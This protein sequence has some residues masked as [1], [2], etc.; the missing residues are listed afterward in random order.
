MVSPTFF[1]SLAL[2]IGL[3]VLIAMYQMKCMENLEKSVDFRDNISNLRTVTF[4]TPLQII[5][6]TVCMELNKQ[7]AF[8]NSWKQLQV[9][10][11]SNGN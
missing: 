6:I 2:S 10:I 7:V 1:Y 8:F 3:I 9:S 11:Y 5:P 4:L